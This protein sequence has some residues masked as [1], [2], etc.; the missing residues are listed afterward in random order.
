[1]TTKTSNV[2][3]IRSDLW[4]T[5]RDSPFPGLTTHAYLWT[6]PEGNVLFYSPATEADFEMIAELGGVAH[7][8]LS[9][10]DEAGPML[11]AVKQRFG[12]RLHASAH[13]RNEIGEHAILDVPI[14][15]RHVDG[16]GV[17][18]IPTPGHSAGS[19][20]YLITGA[21]G[22]KYLFTGDTMFPTEGGTW[23]TFLVPGRGTAD[24]LSGSLELLGSLDPDVVISSAYG[25]NSAVYEL[26]EGRWRELIAQ[27]Q[28]SVRRD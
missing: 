14:D 7:Q 23:S 19:T 17:E 25:G 11:A 12:S 3:Q 22:Q 8:Y 15:E 10:Q 1:M 2:R 26:A 24:E 6:R 9:H 28:Q 20:S 27:A 13:E 5:R 16:N 4:E 21:D 18:A